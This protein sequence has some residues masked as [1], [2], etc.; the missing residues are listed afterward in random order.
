MG[1][2]L[3]VLFWNV[4]S[5]YNKL[6]SIRYEVLN[7]RPH[8]ININETW[9]TE[10]INDS[11]LTI[12]GY[13]L[14][15]NDRNKNIDG[16]I[17]KGGGI[18][19][20]V[21]EG[22]VCNELIELTCI[23]NNIEMSIVRYK[24]P[25]TRDI[26]VVNV[27]RPPAGDI[28]RFFKTLQNCVSTI[29]NSRNCDIFIGGDYNIDFFKKNSPHTKKLSKFT[30]TNQF[31][32]IINTITRP[33]SNTCIDLVVT[34]CDIVRESGSLDVN[35]SDHLPVFFVRK[36]TKT[37][38]LKTSF[39]GR[40][41][42]NVTEDQFIDF[43]NK[44]SWEEFA[45][46]DIDTCWD[47]MYNRI[48]AAADFYCPI[49]DF[50]FSKDKPIWLTNDLIAIM[51]ERDRCFIDYSL[52][53]TEE[54]KAKMR[55]ARNL[56]NVSVKLA[57]ADYI[58]EQLNT[59]KNDPKKF[60][61]NIAEIIPNSKSNIS[62]F[63]NIHDD[64]NNIIPHENLASHVNCFF[65]DIGIKL[66]KTIPQ[67]QTVRIVDRPPVLAHTI[68]RFDCVDE[69]ALLEEINKISI[70]KSSG[71]NNLPTY[72]LRICL[73]ILLQ[74]LLV[75]IN[76]SLFNGYF[77]M[78]WRK[79]IVVPIPKVNIPEEIGDLRPIA[80]TPLPGKI[81]ERFVHNQITSHLDVNNLLTEYQNGFR[82][83][84]STVD[85]IF[86]YTSDLQNNKNSKY[87]TISLYVDFKKAFDTVNHGLLIRKLKLFGITDIALNWIETY[88][89]NRTQQTQIGNDLSNEREVK[90]GVPQGSILGPTFFLCYINDIIDVCQNSKILL[91]ADDTVLYKKNSDKQRFLDMHDFQQDVNRL[92]KWCQKNRL[93][94]NVKKTK[95]VFH[96]HTCTIET[97]VYQD[98]KILGSPVSYVTT[99]MYLG[100]DIDNQLSFKPF[101]A[102]TFKKITY[103]LSLLRR[104]RY[105]ITVKAA[106]DIIK[107]MFCSIIDYGN[108]F[109][110]SRNLNEL[111]DLQTLQNHALRCCHKI[112]DPRDEHVVHLH[113]ISNMVS[114]DVRRKRQILTCI[115][116]NIKKG[117][118]DTSVPTRHTRAAMAPTIY[119]PIP[120][121][122][123]YKKSVF[124][125]GAS[126]WN[127]LPVEIR[128]E[129]DIEGFKLKLYKH[130]L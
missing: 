43:F 10:N 89:T 90:T 106:L 93:S 28:D 35:I 60:W 101:Y 87:N 128:L 21:K 73:K 130:I 126:L 110:F 100:V 20:Y 70:Y 5:L 94:I 58:K 103:K 68:T 72:I 123:L 37:I 38:K 52:A 79:A 48:T 3:K 65:S 42:K 31:R 32:Q 9:L 44:Y 13:T 64:D 36:K 49:K 67:T 80:L 76:K 85:T 99:Y 17:R 97:D 63:S 118:I 107:T 86:R 69:V 18:C 51:K 57:R 82:K 50:K 75:I 117:I 6:D 33:D 29:R 41:Y 121:T 122:E 54:N 74:H 119:L 88:L 7:V 62:N 71:I 96:P 102:N 39:R 46:H 47:I 19:T 2:G 24:L 23:D 53:K 127:Q 116:R 8:I 81:I 91:Y 105:M 104:I 55:R 59:H 40:S 25:F 109:L 108:I 98:I 111:N 30:K 22:L 61:K 115:W 114:V 66:D 120:R 125:Y 45:S 83:K 77:P 15:R 124:Y 56:A 14:I 78:K 113:N 84:H 92:I 12:H 27:Y 95:L 112:T 1:K 34:N 4:R 16:T 129:D 26:Y 11:E